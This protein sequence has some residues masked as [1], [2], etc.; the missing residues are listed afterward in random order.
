MELSFT[1]ESFYEI[2]L[3]LVC[4]AYTLQ[5][6]ELAAL[7]KSTLFM[8]ELFCHKIYMLLLQMNIRLYLG[9]F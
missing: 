9:D 3:F 2:F 7:V 8:K 5:R 1:D 4:I 6:K